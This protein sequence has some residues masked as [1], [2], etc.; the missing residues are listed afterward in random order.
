M[1]ADPPRLMDPL[2]D[3]LERRRGAGDQHH[4][5][6][7]GRQRLGGRRADPAAGSGDQRKLAGKGLRI[8]HRAA[9]SG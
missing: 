3:R 2:L 1:V 7:G 8:S 4:M 5:R 6:A 9:C